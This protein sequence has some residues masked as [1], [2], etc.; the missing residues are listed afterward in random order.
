MFQRISNIPFFC[1]LR[2]KTQNLI[3]NKSINS[4]LK[5]SRSDYQDTMTGSISN[6]N[7][8]S[9]V[10]ISTINPTILAFKQR[11]VT[12]FISRFS[13]AERTHFLTLS[14]NMDEEKPELFQW[15][16]SNVVAIMENDL[17]D[18]PENAVEVLMGED[19]IFNMAAALFLA[20]SLPTAQASRLFNGI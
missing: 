10:I 9:P 2:E 3:G 8:N 16:K 4:F 14:M 15:F 13:K 5:T 12:N 1:R 20:F 19:S 18:M 7:N 11:V 6:N 17:S